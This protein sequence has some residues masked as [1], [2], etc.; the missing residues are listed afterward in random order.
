V[1]DEC[2]VWLDLVIDGCPLDCAKKTM[3]LAGFGGFT[4]L[5]ISDVGFQKGESPANDDNIAAVA[6]VA[7]ARMGA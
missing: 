5:N 7:A 1:W 6:Q 4:H 3:E 2:S